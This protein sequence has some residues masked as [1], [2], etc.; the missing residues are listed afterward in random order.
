MYPLAGGIEG[1]SSKYILNVKGLAGVG[2]FFKQLDDFI[3]IL[4]EMS[5]IGDTLT[6]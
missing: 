5:I 6:N 1:E 4:V 2:S 3:A